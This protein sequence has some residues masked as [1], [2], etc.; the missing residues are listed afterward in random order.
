MTIQFYCGSGSPFAWRVWFALEHKQL[1]YELHM[2]SFSGGDLA[3]PEYAAINP[4]HKVPAIVDNGLAL[5]ESAAIVEY[6]DDQ[7]AESGERLFP[8]NPRRRALVR[9]L[10]RE[11]DQYLAE[12]NERLLDEVL[13]KEPAQWDLLRISQCRDAFAEELA[14][15]ERMLS[16]DWFAGELSAADHAIYPVIALALRMDRRKPDLGMA[17]A[18]GP[19]LRD[20]M[21]RVEALP[22]F[23]KTYP[24]HWRNS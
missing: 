24:P 3:T 14:N 20:W 15:F 5:Y 17:A 22:Y 2:L 23:G 11:T 1:P 4:R 6:L 18:V 19:K 16:G 8:A 10:V 7:Y 9:R 21:R 12:A 13:F